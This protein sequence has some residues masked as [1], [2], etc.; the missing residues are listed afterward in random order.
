[1]CVD[2]ARRC[3]DGAGRHAGLGFAS[4]LD[5][6]FCCA[7]HMTIATEFERA[8]I[9]HKQGKLREAFMRY[10]AVLAADPKHAGAL[11]YSGVVLLQSGKAVE[12]V[13]RIR[14]SIA[15]DPGSADAWSNLALALQTID[16]GAAAVNALKEA[17]KLDSH[18]P[19]IFT[20]L[21]AAELALG[22]VAAAETSARMATTIDGNYAAGWYNLAL[23]LEPQG[24]LLEALDAV[25]RAAGL[26]S[27]ESAYAGF[28]AQLEARLEAPDKARATLEAALARKPTAAALRFQ[29]AGLLESQNE[30]APAAAAFADVLRLDPQNGAALSQLTFLRQR[31]ADWAALPDVWKKFH[32][33]V[34][35]G[36]SML[37]PF[38][39][40]SQPS[41]RAEQRRCADAWTST[42]VPATPHAA[43]GL[44]SGNR[45]RIG[46]LST[47]FHTHATAFLA[48]GMFE[49]H[50]R[51]R[52]EIVAF[53]SGPD[54]GSPMRRRLTRAFERFV[55]VRGSSALK[56][57]EAIRK[58]GIDILVDLKGH[59]EGAPPAV[60]GLRPAPI[61]VHYLGYPGTLGGA[62]VDYL[63]GDPIVTPPQHAADYAETLA[64]LPHSYQV[65]DRSR[66]IEPPPPREALQL[67]RDAVVLCCFNSIYKLNPMVFDA[68]AKIM[69]RAPD[70]VLWLL[71]RRDD[72]PAVGALR[73]EAVKRGLDARRLVFARSRPN[74]EYLGL[75][76]HADLFLDTWPYNAHT[77]AS[78]ALWAGCPV[79]TWRG[80]T[81]AGRV[82][83]SLLTAVGLP[84]L[85]CDDV[86]DYITAAV[87]IAQD[88]DYRARLKHHLAGPGRASPLFD[89]VAT[90][91]AI[92]AAYTAM[93]D[94]YRRH[95]RQPIR[96]G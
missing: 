70:T 84:E 12:A 23:A 21:S 68:W 32:D 35:V 3:N 56:L 65:N 82:A 96:I 51:E 74:A 67:P 95:I 8:Y 38:V 29:L 28:K 17:A 9:L 37:S 69:A 89:T 6:Y 80:E 57:A 11:H 20:N 2:V 58:H 44:L 48:A 45:L 71:A 79:L 85:V 73:K 27:K 30:L 59:T 36:R 66:P 46:Y 47:D 53:S 24:R 54:D 4:L 63:I 94:Q 42:F 91:R 34:V 62:L 19:E 83:A 31:M 60:L 25:T 43:R 1:V 64:L 78:D 90:T 92:E 50:D 52:F 49:A 81:F 86:E 26:A 39:F 61:Q 16:R 75:Y 76:Q 33:G 88:P 13:D 10:G 87:A 77:T 14:A 22:R 7:K 40:L 15:I 18:S 5:S 72:D 41:T 55:D 93:A